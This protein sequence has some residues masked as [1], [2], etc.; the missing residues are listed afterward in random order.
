[1][2][3]HGPKERFNRY[4][5]LE[6]AI[7]GILSESP[8]LIEEIKQV[9]TEDH[10][11]SLSHFSLG[12]QLRNSLGLWATPQDSTLVKWFWDKGLTHADDMSSVILKALFRKVHHVD[13]P[14]TALRHDIEKMQKFWL[15]QIFDE[16][17][18]TW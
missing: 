8:N 13:Y 17:E 6:E 10:F 14:E 11:I 9:K 18:S 16:G 4:K 2:S 1:M 5:T 15:D 12:M 7:S 3:K